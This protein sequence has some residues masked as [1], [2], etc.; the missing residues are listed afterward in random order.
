M[1]VYF[2]YFCFQFIA[3]KLQGTPLSISDQYVF[4][5]APISIKKQLSIDLAVQVWS[6]KVQIFLNVVF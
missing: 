6:I 1:D 2:V 3:N 5:T 4:T